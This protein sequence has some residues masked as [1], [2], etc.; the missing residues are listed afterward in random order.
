MYFI[1]C[2]KNIM[3]IQ[4]CTARVKILMFSTYKMKYIWYLPKKR[5]FSFYFVHFISYQLKK[6]VLNMQ[7][8]NFLANPNNFGTKKC[9]SHS[10]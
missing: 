8:R 6:E 10:N 7:K 3:I 1:E 2:V 4:E 5:K 9:L